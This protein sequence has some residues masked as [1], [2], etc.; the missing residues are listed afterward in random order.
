[1]NGI[2]SYEHTSNIKPT[3]IMKTVA[4]LGTLLIALNLNAQHNAPL[5]L[6]TEA[7]E[8]GT[9][10][11]LQATVVLLPELNMAM[12]GR[13][14]ALTLAEGFRVILF[15]GEEGE[16]RD[17]LVLVGPCTIS[18][19]KTLPRLHSPGHWDDSIASLWL[20]EL[21]K[22]SMPGQ[23]GVLAGTAH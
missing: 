1:M 17:Q 18:D 19:L 7:H 12:Q 22:E 21:P 14:S 4:T 8:Q 16:G 15:D 5:T 2:H 23:E 10:C 13:V 9:S 6:W 3:W 20:E 11:H